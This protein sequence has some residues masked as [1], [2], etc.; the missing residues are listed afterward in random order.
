MYKK[1]WKER[2]TSFV[3]MEK[4]QEGA[5]NKG[6]VE[7]DEQW[8]R[9]ALTMR[10]M[11][12]EERREA[13]DKIGSEDEMMT[14]LLALLFD[15][16]T[17][18]ELGKT[19]IRLELYRKMLSSIILEQENHDAPLDVSKLPQALEKGWHSFKE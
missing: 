17:R 5:C 2:L 4:K 9:E 19:L 13:V 15:Q 7:Q 1:V 14:K 16:I 18:D 10:G 12:D 8:Q 3:V 11:N 6:D